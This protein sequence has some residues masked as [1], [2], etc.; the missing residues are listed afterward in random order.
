M[1]QTEQKTDTGWVCGVVIDETTAFI[2][3]VRISLLPEDASGV[4]GADPVAEAKTDVHGQFCLQDLPPGFY[5]LRPQRELWP[6]Q[7]PRTVEVRA[8]L[9]NRLTPAIELELEPG[10]PRVSVQDSL[11]AMQ[12]GEARATVES[13]LRRGDAASVQELAR[14]LLPKRGPVLPHNLN[15]L[16]IGL[17]VKP[18]LDELIRQLDR[19]L[20]PLKT[21]RYVYLAGE[22]ADPK[23]RDIVIPVLLRSLRDGRPLPKRA[24]KRG[25]DGEGTTFVSDIAIVA[26][27]RFSGNDFKWKYGTPPLQNQ[28][29][30][31]RADDWWR[32][33]LE[34]EADKQRQ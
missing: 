10:E 27:A 15:R 5:A 12:P 1:A 24:V 29:P 13:L 25:E 11:D 33:E 26:L 16:V 7:P 9:V 8:G 23:T 6:P 3:D 2:A 28:S 21:A 34:K 20:P 18:L 4:P 19:G 17:D 31:T 32:R 14:R 22:L 30:I